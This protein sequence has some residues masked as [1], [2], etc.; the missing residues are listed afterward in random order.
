MGGTPIVGW[1][2]MEN[3]MWWKSP[4]EFIKKCYKKTVWFHH[5]SGE[6]IESLVNKS[7]FL[8]AKLRIQVEDPLKLQL[9]VDPCWSILIQTGSCHCSGIFWGTKKL[10]LYNQQMDTNG[11]FRKWWYPRSSSLSIINHQFLGYPDFRKPP[12]VNS[13][14]FNRK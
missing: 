2:V 14:R 1:C 4:D 13:V 3:P 8:G 5:D 12:N 9:K 6:P 11:G 10:F 7:P